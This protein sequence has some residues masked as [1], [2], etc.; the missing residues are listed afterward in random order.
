MTVLVRIHVGDRRTWG[1]EVAGDDAEHAVASIAEEIEDGEVID[2]FP[3]TDE[4]E[5]SGSYRL[6]RFPRLDVTVS[7][8]APTP[9]PG[10]DT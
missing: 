3:A 4:G 8:Q 7:A 9:L 1:T 2:A 6:V 10:G 5:Q